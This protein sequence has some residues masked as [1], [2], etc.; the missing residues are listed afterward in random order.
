MTENPDERDAQTFDGQTGEPDPPPR[1]RGRLDL[2]SVRDVRLELAALYR[3]VKREKMESGEAN[4][5]A[6]LLRQISDLIVV[7]ELEQR[8]KALEGVQP[9]LEMTNGRMLN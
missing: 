1:K 7:A 2:S 3:L 6:W 8:I 5:R 4:K 9:A